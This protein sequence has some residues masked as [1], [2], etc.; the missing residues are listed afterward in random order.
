MGGPYPD[1]M[2]EETSPSDV[3]DAVRRALA[4]RTFA[5]S[6]RSRAFLS[7]VVSELL[8]GR[9]DRLSERIVARGA[10]GHD[11]SF[12]G[13]DNSSV[14]VAATRVR[15]LLDRYYSTEGSAELLRVELP[16]GR[17]V[18]VIR[19]VPVL[20]PATP[21]PGVL[22]LTPEHAGDDEAGPL[23]GSI[24]SGL[25][26]VLSQYDGIRVVG[27]TEPDADPGMA[28]RRIG[29]SHALQGH[30]QVHDSAVRLTAHLISSEGG[31]VVWS[32][33]SDHPVRRAD[34]LA[35]EE[36]W[37]QEVASH[38]ADV[39]G[40][41]IGDFLRRS[42]VDDVTEPALAA[43]LAY[44]A[45]IDRST[46]QSI[47]EAASALDAALALGHRSAQ[48]LAMRGAVANAAVLQGC[49]D[50]D[51][52]TDLAEALAREALGVD[53]GSA[54]AYLV[55][56]GAARTRHRWAQCRQ[57]ADAAA[58]LAPWQPTNLVSAGLLHASAGAWDEGLALIEEGLRLN[59]RLPVHV[60]LWLALGN[61]ILGNYDRALGE[62]TLIDV[63]GEVFGPLYRALALSGLGDL[64]GAG[65]EIVRLRAIDPG[66]LDDVEGRFTAALNLTPEQV[67]RIADLLRRAQATSGRRST[68]IPS[69]GQVSSTEAGEADRQEDHG[70]QADPQ[71]A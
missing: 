27:P 33:T 41:L 63:D 49:G 22:L 36:A 19:P 7:F 34:A 54:H 40:V 51:S 53:A 9:G 55:L 61:V 4:S 42:I 71:Q 39:G 67:S 58:A 59:P 46:K 6:P 12:S 43:R 64:E 11:S 16:A 65:A 15:Q 24:A 32:K 69:A 60:H 28:A 35:L 13:V 21:V 1:R 62:A 56:G 29:V 18:P 2:P 23:A 70:G 31:G 68:P 14:R 48:L 8:A 10:F 26:A 25:A 45:Y 17:Y 52:D 47:E 57:F 66:F 37:A 44:F 20:D 38:I 50:A 30:V 3:A 5:R